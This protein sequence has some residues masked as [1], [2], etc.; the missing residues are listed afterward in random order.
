MLEEEFFT[1]AGGNY[2]FVALA[3]VLSVACVYLTR[4]FFKKI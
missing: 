1:L 4:T 2:I 3:L